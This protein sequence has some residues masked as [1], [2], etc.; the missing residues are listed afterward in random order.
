M[1]LQ[2]AKA[3]VFFGDNEV[4]ASAKSL[5]NDG[6]IKIV[7]GGEVEYFHILFDQHEIIFAEGAM[8]ESLHIGAQSLQSLP[9]D[10][11]DEIEMLFPNLFT[12]TGGLNPTARQ[13][14]KTYEVRALLAA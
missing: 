2:S 1:V 11:I 13:V 8:V 5:V 10:A 9:K 4:L 14:L 7:E 12:P 6:S 3:E